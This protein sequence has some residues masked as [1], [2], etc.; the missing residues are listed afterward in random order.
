MMIEIGDY[1]T[2]LRDVL[3]VPL[4]NIDFILGREWLA[5]AMPEVA[6][7]TGVI[8]VKSGE[9]VCTLQPL[10]ENRDFVMLMN[11]K[12]FERYIRKKSVELYSV[13]VRKCDKIG[14]AHDKTPV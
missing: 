8:K 6:W 10:P 7:D 5:A 2:V 1:Q 11:T 14:R 4:F 13:V 3:A 9:D 12:K